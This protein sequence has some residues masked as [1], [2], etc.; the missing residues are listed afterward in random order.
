MLVNIHHDSP[1][2]HRRLLVAGVAFLTV[3]ALLIGAVDRDL[4]EGLRR[5]H[6]GHDQGRPGRPPAG[7]VR[8]RPRQRRPGRPGP[9]DQ[10]GRR[11]GRRSRSPS[12]RTPPSEIPDNVEVQILPDDPVRPEVRLLRRPGR[13]RRPRRSQDGD[14][15]PSDRVET[16]VELNRILADLFPLL[17]A[18]RPADLNATLNALATALGGRGEQ[19]G[20]T[21]DKLDSYLG[22]IDDHLPTLRKD[23]DPAGRRRRHLR[24]RRARPARRSCDNVTVTSRTVARAAT[25]ARRLLRRRGRPGRHLDRGSWPT[26]RP[27]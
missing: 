9:R 2:E 7:Q 15:I 17:R 27:T 6:D 8:R 26:T 1:A 14:V 25:G 21:L 5:R 11:G 13:R 20:E 23:L 19:L 16:N 10:P 22:A 4:P 24:R 18:V 12:S 3:I